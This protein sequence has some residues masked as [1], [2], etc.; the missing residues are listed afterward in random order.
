MLFR[1][2]IMSNRESGFGRYDVVLEPKDSERNAIV[3]EFKVQ[4]DGE[5]DLSDTVQD[6]L[7]QI[8]EKQY[9]ADLVRRGISQERIRKYGFA[10]RGKTV[11]I[12]SA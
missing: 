12:G 8:E 9:Q 2:V 3:I 4:D 7:R 1:S 10:F 5:R 11:L 6:A